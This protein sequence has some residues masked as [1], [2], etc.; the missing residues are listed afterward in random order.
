MITLTTKAKFW[1]TGKKLIRKHIL[2]TFLYM[3]MSNQKL[4]LIDVLVQKIPQQKSYALI[5]FSAFNLRL[6]KAVFLKP[7]KYCDIVLKGICLVSTCSFDQKCQFSKFLFRHGPRTVLY[8]L[9]LEILNFWVC[10][11][12]Q[13]TFTIFRPI[14]NSRL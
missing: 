10:L 1:S 3:P 9:S 7:P 4:C 14:A 13:Y 12:M 6:S 5:H 11:W 8:C 2:G